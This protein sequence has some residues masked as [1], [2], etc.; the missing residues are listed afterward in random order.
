M[1]KSLFIVLTLL[2]MVAQGAWADSSFGGGDGSAK[3]PYIINTTAHWDQFASDVNGGTT[4]SDTYFLLGDDITVSTMVGAGTK[5][6]DA[7]PFSGT[8][9]GGGH[10]LTF[11][12]TATEAEGDVAPF[13]FVRS[14]TI[15][16]MHV[17]GEINTAYKHAAGLSTRAYGTTLIKNCRV[18]TVI[19]SSVVGD[20]TH[21]GIVV[22]KPDYNSAKL[23]I[24]G[25]VFDGKILTTQTGNNAS[26]HCGGFV[27]YTSYGSLTIKN[28]IYA[29]AAPAAN[30]T[31]V[32]SQ[33]TF[34]RYS[35]AHPGTITLDKCYYT[36]P[37]GG[38]QGKQA[39][40]FGFP[41]GVDIDI[42]PIGEATEYSVSG[43]TVYEGNLSMKYNGTLYAGSGDE[44]D[45]KFINNYVGCNVTGYGVDESTGTKLTQKGTGDYTLKMGS[46]NVI[47]GFS[48]TGPSLLQIPG[49]GTEASPY[50]I[51]DSSVWDYIVSLVNYTNQN[52]DA[53]YPEYASAYYKLTAD[54]VV[55]TMLGC[56]S[57][58]FS[59]HFDGGIYDEDHNLTGYHTL[60]VNYDT[61]EP[62]TAP[63]RY[64]QGAEISNLRVAGTI[65][66]SKQ[67][68][69]GF[70]ANAQGSNTMTN[71]RSSVTINSS[72]SGDG[73]HGGFV[74]FNT[75]GQFTMTG[76]AFDG[77]LLGS[78]TNKCGGFVGWNETNG[79]P[80]G[81]VKFE[82]CF[83]APTSITV[84]LEHTYARSRINDGAHVQMFY[85]NCRTN[86]NDSQQFRVYSIS[87][88][89]GV[90]IAANQTVKVTYSV[91]GITIYDVGMMYDGVL[92]ARNEQTMS[93]NLG[94]TGS[95]NVTGF[96]TTSGTLIVDN[97]YTLTMGTGDAIINA[98]TS[99]T[100]AWSGSGSGTSESPYI[101]SSTAQWDEFAHKVDNGVFG[102]NTAYYKL[103][104]D[105]TVTTMVGTESHKFKG[106]FDGGGKTL[107]L[108]Y[109]T[110]QEPFSEDYCAPFR[111]IENA[112]FN[113]LCIAGTIYTKNMF[114]AGLAGFALNDNTITNCLCSV[115][116]NSSVN[117]DG[118][119]GGFV[120]NCQNNVD[121]KTTVTFTNCAFNG[122]LIGA[123]TN[124][125]G[126]FVGWEESNE[127][128]AVKFTNCLFAPSEVNVDN[129]GSATFSRGR[130][131][132]LSDYIIIENSYYTRSLGTMQGEMAYTTPP[133][134]VTSEAKTIAGITVY[135]KNTPVTDV[136]ATGI[137]PNTAIISWTGTD[138]CSNYQVRYRV[139]QNTDVYSTS[140]EDGLPEGWTTFDNDDDNEYGWTHEDGTKKGMAHSGSSCMYSASYINNY[141]SLEPDNWLVSKPLDLRGTLKVWLKGQDGDEY[142]EHFAIY[143]STA[144]GS[145]SDFLKEDGSLQD[146]VVTLVPETETSN[147]YQEYTADLSTYSGQGYIAIRHFNCY[148]EFYL[149]LDDFL[150]YDD[151]ASGAWTTVS[152]ASSASTTLDGLTPG[153]TYEYQVV[154]QYGN[155]T[156]YTPT[157][158]LNTLAE[159]VAPTDLSIT[160][161]TANAATIGWK[162]F[163]DS[164][165]LRYSKG[166]LAKVTL[167]V[168]EDVWDDGS[169]YQMLLD[170]DHDTYGN[171]SVIP[172]SGGMIGD[173]DELA[174][175]YA[176]F[177]SKIPGNADSDVNTSNM[178]N[179]TEGKK[180]ATITIPAG[181][182]DW[183][184][185]NPTPN[186]RMWIASEH[187]NVGGR[188]DDFVFEAGKHYTF[189]VTFDYESGYDFVNMTVEDDDNLATG[190]VIDVTGV[191]GTSY[192]LSGL[193][194]STYYTVYVQSVKGENI[195]EW[196]SVTFTTDATS[197]G[198]VDD[199]DNTAAITAAITANNG[200]PC[201]VTLVGRT[202]YKDGAWNTLCLPFDVSVGSDVMEGA[203]AMTLNGTTSNFNSES[204][205]LMLNFDEVA[206]GST[207]A[208]G[209]PFIVKWT[210]SNVT[211]PVFSGV[212]I[213][214]TTAGSVT[215]G[216]NLVQFIGTYAPVSLTAG[217][218]S[219]LYLGSGNK[220]Y[221]PSTTRQI[222]AFRGYFHVNLGTNATVRAFVLNFGD[223]ET[224]GI[225]STTN[226]TN[227]DDAW[228]DLSGRKLSG[229]PTKKGVYIVKNSILTFKTKI[230]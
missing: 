111:Y 181:T 2:C 63:F 65:K 125:W 81:A 102:F 186:D 129:D 25:C 115:T 43:I 203:M 100:S 77:S 45:L 34:Y 13:R 199:A 220:L 44:V 61:D 226:Y 8:F 101:I 88:G 123:S 202:L 222:N 50:I 54:I 120:A 143:L 170:K 39:L 132:N 190:E 47:I 213:S 20:A 29:P 194:A 42:V 51:S 38:A 60:T 67:F 1:K 26:T 89:D 122:Q 27:G 52:G 148:D 171:N 131:N 206:S 141:G 149:V 201:D 93:L 158:I 216:D 172:T 91:S 210:G 162:G 11:N 92:Y 144:G 128:A 223:G 30:E 154:Y 71:C 191:T 164:Y 156:Y 145:K 97:P 70:V 228:Y 165:N 212:T 183:C 96:T 56:A 113:N 17:A 58:R 105:I 4:Y 72:V 174:A 78:S 175:K 127:W 146:G 22:M 48:M 192:N 31:A 69:G 14:A 155:N 136:A 135:V 217:N 166:G 147:I 230:L 177:E 218:Q 104:D 225:I 33:Y 173:A 157:M 118:T 167:S 137:T 64:V 214:S 152:N 9:D 196:G 185:T 85:S 204:G 169:G 98:I 140:F 209:T 205:V 35:D 87:A 207:I 76:C 66:T 19:K 106:H 90:T 83:F 130:N 103:T 99:S 32:S 18:S 74:A 82:N 139:K 55:T 41:E 107:T 86:I 10:T 176:L 59:G 84:D 110:A 219:N 126:G 68:A 12:H 215:S 178:L 142:R 15:C 57:N 6:K 229:K 163:G 109:G 224:T 80:S 116:I 180:S 3:N 200:Q 16:N 160:S 208:A 121:H 112:E 79:S 134:N 188:Q 193:A 117:G 159:D 184:I 94:Y 46:E 40:S 150:I 161:I 108:S 75:G 21:G 23:T 138:A 179:G 195:S 197:I 189:T 28:S 168:P 198:L 119:H 153:T 7:K 133:A 151:N 95:G 73:T 37:L 5:S 62:Y 221:Y 49:K 124:N 114:S 227:S 211:A 36:Q 24:E 182:Y 187:G 53:V